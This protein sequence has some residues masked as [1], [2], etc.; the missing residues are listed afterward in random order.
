MAKKIY[1]KYTQ[2]TPDE[3]KRIKWLADQP[4]LSN[5]QI[6]KIMGRSDA[7][8]FY[9]KKSE[10]FNDY[11]SIIR[12]MSDRKKVKPAVETT[13]EETPGLVHEVTAEPVETGPTELSRIADALEK[14]VVAWETAPKKKSLF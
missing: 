9:I 10:D 4:G 12:E 14:L 7:T 5:V 3:Y 8:V 6:A 2:M 1:K 11:R 13:L